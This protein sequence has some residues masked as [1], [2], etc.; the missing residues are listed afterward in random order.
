ML[1]S[2]AE[3]VVPQRAGKLHCV[4]QTN[5]ASVADVSRWVLRPAIE[6]AFRDANAATA[7][8]DF[9]AS[10]DCID[11]LKSGHGCRVPS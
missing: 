4:V 9:P 8:A 7:V 6:A 10:K 11:R 1:S 2:L 3:S 5:V